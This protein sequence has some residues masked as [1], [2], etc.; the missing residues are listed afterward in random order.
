MQVL[1]KAASILIVPAIAF[2]MSACQKTDMPTAPVSPTTLAPSN[3]FGFGPSAVYWVNDDDPNGGAYA[4]PGTSC[5]NPG[6]P[7]IQSAV[8]AAPPGTRIN[9]CP[10]LYLEQVVIPVG[11]DNIQLRSVQPWQ[12]IIKAPPAMFP[13]PG[14]FS[15]VNVTG[16]HNVS[17]L[18][19][20]VTGPGPGPCGTI[21]YGVRIGETGSA[22][23]LGNHI[24]DIRDEPFSGCQNGVAVGV[25][26]L[27]DATTGSAWIVG[28]FI[29]R[30][31]KNGPTVSNVGSSAVIAYNRVLGIG[32]TTTIAQNGIQVS[33]GATASVVS[34]FVARNIY[35]PATVV[36][37]GIL[38]FSSG[39]VF[40]EHNTVTSND[41]GIYMF[42]AGATSMTSDN[43]SR[44]STFDGIAVDASNGT[45]VAHNWIDQNSGPGVGMY[46][47]AS[48]NS[49]SDN[50]VE[51]NHDS[52]I[53]LDVAL[54]NTV[55]SNWVR[56]NGTETGDLTDGIRANPGSVGNTIRDNRL[57]SNVTHDCHD[58]NAAGN[59]WINNRGQTSFPPG[60]C[61]GG[62]GGSDT[63]HESTFGW[64][65]GYPWYLAFG[66]RADP[67]ATSTVDTQSLLQLLPTTKAAVARGGL[68]PAQ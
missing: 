32:A 67:G 47:A 18:G 49:V 24:V 62:E 60:L 39:K 43:R 6:Y 55:G 53:L 35:S 52:G 14:G 22:F 3:L 12:A 17:L 1:R 59:S 34:N 57:R 56:N 66:E 41:V 50:R 27:A 44:A 36:S 23:V 30:Y 20:T 33:G 26:R 40:T 9:V 45:R 54:S 16:A 8:T 10:G 51:Y 5:D 65:A 25:G 7:T 28:N 4:P 48:N 31:Q 15:I 42:D 63:E 46:D 11:K 58:G 19:F 29:E 68:S 2:A 64:N 38:L 13:G 21:H 61:R 37:T